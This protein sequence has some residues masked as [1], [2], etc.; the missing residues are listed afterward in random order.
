M[1]E[2]LISSKYLLPR[3]KHHI[4]SYPTR[5]LKIGVIYFGLIFCEQNT[6]IQTFSMTKWFLFIIFYK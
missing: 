1:A 3:I 6:A 4:L 2:N 5:F